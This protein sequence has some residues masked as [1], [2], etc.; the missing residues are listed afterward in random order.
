MTSSAMDAVA[1]DIETSGLEPDCKITAVAI[2]GP[3]WHVCYTF[4][5]HNDFIANRDAILGILD[6]APLIYTF[7][8]PGFDIPVMQRC[9]GLDDKIIGAW[10]AKLVDPLY[11]AKG[12]IGTKACAKLD[13]VLALNGMPAKTGSGLE[14]VH[15]AREGRWRELEDY[16]LH[17]TVVTRKLLDCE[18]IYWAES[19]RYR[20][21]SRCVWLF[22]LVG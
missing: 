7:N 18:T 9:F 17:D 14:A 5:P 20:P 15:M 19:L 13:V 10:M 11:A 12:L 8:G 1:I 4:G 22:T 21:H 6:R 16:C 2:A 3:D